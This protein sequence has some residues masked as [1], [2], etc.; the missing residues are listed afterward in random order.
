M[1]WPE[2]NTYRWTFIMQGDEPF[3]ADDLAAVKVA[4]GGLGVFQ[5]G[6]D[7]FKIVVSY[8]T[9][10][11]GRPQ[12]A[13]FGALFRRYPELRFTTYANSVKEAFGDRIQRL[14]SRPR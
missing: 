1:I 14:H 11:P 13:A 8:T 4:T 3:T 2:T 12:H 6:R 5:G 9:A 7:P 10:T